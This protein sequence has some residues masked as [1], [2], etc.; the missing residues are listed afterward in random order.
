MGKDTP[1]QPFDWERFQWWRHTYIFKILDESIDFKHFHHVFDIW[2]IEEYENAKSHKDFKEIMLFQH[3]E[4]EPHNWDCHNKQILFHNWLLNLYITFFKEVLD[5][6]FADMGYMPSF[7]KFRIILPKKEYSEIENF[8]KKY[9][10]SLI[11]DLIYEIIAEAQNKYTEHIDYLYKFKSE[12]KYKYHIKN[13][14]KKAKDAIDIIERITESE[15]YLKEDKVPPKLQFIQFAFGDGNRK[16]TDSW[17]MLDIVRGFKEHLEKIGYKDWRKELEFYP[18]RYNFIIEEFKFKQY[19]AIAFY[20]LLIKGGFI[21]LKDP[22]KPY[23]NEVRECI[24]ELFKFCL[25]PIGA[26]TTSPKNIKRIIL[27]W[28]KPERYKLEEKITQLPIRINK[29]KLL[30]Y[31]DSDFINMSTEIKGADVL[32]LASL[33]YSRFNMLNFETVF[34]DLVHIIKCQKITNHFLSHQLLTEIPPNPPPCDDYTALRNLIEGL[35]GNRNITQFKFKIEGKEEEFSLNERLPLY[36]LERALNNH[37]KNHKEDFEVDII[38]GKVIP[39]ERPGYYSIKYENK[40][41]LPEERF[42]VKFVKSMYDY[43]TNEVKLKDCPDYLLIETY[44]SIIGVLLQ[45][46]WFFSQLMDSEDFIIEK[47]KL[48]HQ[49]SQP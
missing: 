17:L 31:F 11:H 36:I 48:W 45:Q 7:E 38:K 19:L 23:P 44:Y 4:D 21:K 42:I 47:V 18:N 5:L 43:L 28:L 6:D 46:N 20:N 2:S 40:L 9:N 24:E 34:P 25:I 30:K 49:L 32:N 27:N 33:L 41:N 35:N 12:H 39:D 1:K 37:F 8:I 14:P 15:N 29:E 10:L 13:I 26:E 22:K 3:I 16:I